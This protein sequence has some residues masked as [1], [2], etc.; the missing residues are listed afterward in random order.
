MRRLLRISTRQQS[1]YALN[2]TEELFATEQ[3]EQIIDRLL[4]LYCKQIEE[5]A[6]TMSAVPRS[7]T[8]EL[9]GLI[10]DLPDRTALN[11]EWQ[12]YQQLA[13]VLFSLDKQ[14]ATFLP[15]VR[16]IF[17]KKLQL[18][19]NDAD[20]DYQRIHQRMY[21]YFTRRCAQYPDQSAAVLERGYHALAL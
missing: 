11:A 13:F 18:T 3:G 1:P 20:S 10:L 12:R 8:P 6:F 5:R 15:G 9:L 17:L 21:D 16:A 7:L 2:D 19:A 4:A 14:R